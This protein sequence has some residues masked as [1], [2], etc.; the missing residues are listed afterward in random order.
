MFLEKNERFL[1]I[2]YCRKHAHRQKKRQK[3][4]FSIFARFLRRQMKSDMV[5]MPNQVYLPTKG[6]VRLYSEAF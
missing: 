5:G 2:F 4:D 3:G 6:C 1:M